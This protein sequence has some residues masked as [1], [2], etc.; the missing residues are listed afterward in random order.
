MR[1]TLELGS[2]AQSDAIAAD[3]SSLSISGTNNTDVIGII[4]NNS[5]D[6]D[7]DVLRLSLSGISNPAASNQY[8][9]FNDANGVI[10][11]ISGTGGGNVNLALL[12]MENESDNALKF[13][14]KQGVALESSGADYAEYIE[15]ADVAA[16]YLPGDLVGIK[17]GKV[18]N[19]NE[20]ADRIMSVSAKPIVVG[21]APE[22]NKDNYTL[23]AFVGQVY[24]KVK[25]AVVSGQYVIASDENGVGVAKNKEDL[26]ATDISRVV[27]QVWETSNNEKTRLIK[28][29]ITPMDMSLVQT[30]RIATLEQKMQTMMLQMEALM[31]NQGTTQDV[32]KA[33][34]K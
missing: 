16:V 23:V 8:I 24:V 5:T 34:R 6:S 18:V 20:E 13:M 27:G 2:S 32:L 1:S 12:D 17:N 33:E 30:E 25:G 11:G 3:G 10:G 15:K 31:Q 9:Q 7:A 28:V 14:A 22:G 26:T 4:A 21:N 29:G 19:S